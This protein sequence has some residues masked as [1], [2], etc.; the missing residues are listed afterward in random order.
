VIETC[1]VNKKLLRRRFINLGLCYALSFPSRR[2]TI[3]VN[4]HDLVTFDNFNSISSIPPVEYR[5]TYALKSNQ[6]NPTK[7]F[8]SSFVMIPSSSKLNG[9]FEQSFCFCQG[10][11]VPRT[12]QAYNVSEIP[13]NL[14]WYIR[15]SSAVNFADPFVGSTPENIASGSAA[16]L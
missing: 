7:F 10:G 8:A 1:S 4:S 15:F 12:T 16:P 3:S 5:A 11:E 14:A 9:E 2:Q 13:L 6:E